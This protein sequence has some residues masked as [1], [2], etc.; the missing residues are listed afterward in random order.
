MRAKLTVSAS[1]DLDSHS[2][3]NI[4]AKRYESDVARYYREVKQVK[5]WSV[6]V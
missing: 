1:V 2:D 5:L 6:I 3:V 4:P